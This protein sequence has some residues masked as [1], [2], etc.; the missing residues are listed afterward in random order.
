MHGDKA[1]QGNTPTHHLN[2][3][4][5]L[6]TIRYSTLVELRPKRKTFQ[7]IRGRVAVCMAKCQYQKIV[8]SISIKNKAK[9]DIGNRTITST[10]IECGHISFISYSKKTAE[11]EF[12]M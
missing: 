1:G 2:A 8:V 6:P 9:E 12:I 4:I 5:G 3:L 11:T 7:M 10:S